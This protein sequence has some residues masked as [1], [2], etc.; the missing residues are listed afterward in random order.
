MN[1]RLLSI[2]LVALLAMLAVGG[3]QE[4]SAAHTAQNLTLVPGASG[5][6]VTGGY[7]FAGTAYASKT[8]FKPLHNQEAI[9]IDCWFK[10]VSVAAGVRYIVS[11]YVASNTQ[12]AIWQSNVNLRFSIGDGA[13]LATVNFTNGQAGMVYH[14]IGTWDKDLNGG[15]LEL[16]VNGSRSQSSR[17]VTVNSNADDTMFLGQGDGTFNKADNILYS[18]GIYFE[19]WGY[20][21]SNKTHACRDAMLSTV[22]YYFTLNS[23]SG[24]TFYDW[25]DAWYYTEAWDLDAV[26]ASLMWY[27][28]EN[29]TLDVYGLVQTWHTAQTMI[30]E[31]WTHSILP[32]V[33]DSWF[34][35]MILAA[36]GAIVCFALIAKMIAE[37]DYD[38][39]V[40][41]LLFL[42]GLFALLMVAGVILTV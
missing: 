25:D 38:V 33:Q 31:V 5:A 34:Y 11:Q 12:I 6:W 15:R 41:G 8:G 21:E 30:L 3:L 7:N 16:F 27:T 37:G 19:K 18:V 20:A 35:I 17:T 28:V 23:G 40:M 14:L 1:R 42:L 22:D 4:V 24:T 39:G 36:L 9:T 32:G 26:T 29:W 2:S 13:T 10:V